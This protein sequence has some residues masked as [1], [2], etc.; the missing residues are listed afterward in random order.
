M[1]L[2]ITILFYVLVFYLG[3]FLALSVKRHE[4]F[5]LERGAVLYAI[6]LFVFCFFYVQF[7]PM[8][9]AT[10]DSVLTGAFVI[11]FIIRFVRYDDP[12]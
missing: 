2:L 5:Y 10:K 7:I 9:M 12:I 1:G 11:G 6:A 4:V 8:I 3:V